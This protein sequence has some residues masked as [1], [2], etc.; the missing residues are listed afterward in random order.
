MTKIAAILAALVLLAVVV[1]GCGESTSEARTAKAAQ[2]CAHLTEKQ[3]AERGGQ[4]R[5]EELALTNIED[6][7]AVKHCDGR[8][9]CKEEALAALQKKQ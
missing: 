1:A 8:E 6:E 3:E 4:Q 2:V 5:C 9:P 7:E